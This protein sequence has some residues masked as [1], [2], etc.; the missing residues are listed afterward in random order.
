M[1]D[2]FCGFNFGSVSRLTR[3]KYNKEIAVFEFFGKSFQLF[4]TFFAVI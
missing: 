4:S 3:Q 1:V 2:W